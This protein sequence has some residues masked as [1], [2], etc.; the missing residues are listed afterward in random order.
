[1]KTSQQMERHLKGVANH[2]RIDIIF[3]LAEN[4]TLSLEKIVE[5]VNGNTKTISEHTH[6]LHKAGLINKEY[7]GRTVIHF[8][9]PYGKKFH[10]FLKTFQHS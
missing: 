4:K 2:W 9:S 1:M 5:M 10:T 3:A 7:S 8:L 6:R